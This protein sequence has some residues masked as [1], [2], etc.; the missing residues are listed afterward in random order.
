MRRTQ[1]QNREANAASGDACEAKMTVRAGQS[2]RRSTC[3]CVYLSNKNSGI[4]GWTVNLE[5][6]AGT[7][8]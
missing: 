5:S 2:T 7:T 6:T 4:E 8:A 3:V 1:A